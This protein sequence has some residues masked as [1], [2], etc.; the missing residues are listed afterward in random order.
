MFY[1]HHIGCAIT[2]MQLSGEGNITHIYGTG[3]IAMGS[4]YRNLNRY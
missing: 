4:I 2:Y 1:M 3:S